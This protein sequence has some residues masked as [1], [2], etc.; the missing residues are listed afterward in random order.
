L[1]PLDAMLDCWEVVSFF[2]F[3]FLLSL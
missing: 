3:F 2:V 1:W